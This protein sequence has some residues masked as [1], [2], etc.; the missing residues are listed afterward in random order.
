MKWV[1]PVWFEAWPTQRFE[2]KIVLHCI[3]L[4]YRAR[5]GWDREVTEDIFRLGVPFNS[6]PRIFREF[7]LHKTR[8][9][10]CI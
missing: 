10:I 3:G 7:S 8:T 6:V 4:K 9:K 1:P 2:E 5:Q